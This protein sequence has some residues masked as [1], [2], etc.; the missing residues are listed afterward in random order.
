VSISSPATASFSISLNG[1]DQ[2]PTYALAFTVTNT[3]ATKN[4][5]WR[6]S[7]S[8]TQFTNGTKTFPATA[9]SV[10]GVAATGACSGTPCT[11]VLPSGTVAYPVTLPNSGGIP[12]YSAALN[13]GSGTNSLTAT[14]Q[15]AAPANIYAGTYTSTV[16]L[17]IVTGP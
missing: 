4:D 7:A 16:T 17:Q 10:V 8:A 12:I 13:S 1:A 6:V 3:A 11:A 9:S 14:V 5:G 15:V 2:T